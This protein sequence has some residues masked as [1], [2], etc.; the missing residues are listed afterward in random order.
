MEEM[1]FSGSNTLKILLLQS[2]DI[3]AYPR[4][5]PLG[6]RSGKA[7]PPER[8]RIRFSPRYVSL[9]PGITYEYNFSCKFPEGL[10]RPLQNSSYNLRSYANPLRAQ[11]FP[12]SQ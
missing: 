8:L 2:R 4:I 1:F 12:L 3:R 10:E 9:F 6:R 11:F 5:F 7:K